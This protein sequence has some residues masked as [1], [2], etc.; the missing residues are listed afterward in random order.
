M[1][2]SPGCPSLFFIPS[3]YVLFAGVST[4]PEESSIYCNCEKQSSV[5]VGF[6]I[7]FVA[8]FAAISGAIPRRFESPVVYTGDLKSRLKSRKHR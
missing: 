3:D 5:E 7:H 1:T 8:I 2:Q 6:G 4:S